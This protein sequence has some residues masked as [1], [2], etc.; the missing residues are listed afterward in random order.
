MGLGYTIP[1]KSTHS[2]VAARVR[3]SDGIPFDFAVPIL[4]VLSEAGIEIISL[5]FLSDPL[6]SLTI[7]PRPNLQLYRDKANLRLSKPAAAQQR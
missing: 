1:I 2:A 6:V 7:L 5:H 4:D 3:R